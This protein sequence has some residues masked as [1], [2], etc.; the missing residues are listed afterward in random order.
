MRNGIQRHAVL[1]WQVVSSVSGRTLRLKITRGLM[2]Q[3]RFACIYG[4]IVLN[5]YTRIVV[6]GLFRVY[7]RERRFEKRHAVLY[8]QGVSRVS[9]EASL[10]KITRGLSLPELF[11]CI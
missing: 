3:M 5:K 1:C 8:W 10:L 9:E 6:D 7:L 2:K 4:N 11:A